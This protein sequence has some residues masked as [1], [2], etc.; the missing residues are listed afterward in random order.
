MP[1]VGFD[2]PGVRDLVRESGHGAAVDPARGPE[3]LLAGLDEVVA[4][5]P[6][7]RERAAGLLARCAPRTVAVELQR[8]YETCCGST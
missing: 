8:L 5:G 7:D 1:T 6:V 4:R 2:V 3:G